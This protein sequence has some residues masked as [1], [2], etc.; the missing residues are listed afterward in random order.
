MPFVIRPY[1]RFPMTTS[2]TY[3]RL[4]EDGEGTIWNLSRNG[5]HLSGTL[6]LAVGDVC[7]LRSKLPANTHVSVLAGVV[8]W[9]RG[10]EFGI[11]TL[12]MEKRAQ[13]RLDA[14]I[15][16]RLVLRPHRM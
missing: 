5:L 13:G 4:F 9:A 6:P 7:S 10:E 11:E 2:V 3:E 14:D 1:R 15:R 16:D 8:R 12:V